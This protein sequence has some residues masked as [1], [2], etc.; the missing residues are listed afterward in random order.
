[1]LYCPYT[2]SPFWKSQCHTR[3]QDATYLPHKWRTNGADSRQAAIGFC[4]VYVSDDALKHFRTAL[5]DAADGNWKELSKN[6]FY[7]SRFA[8]RPSVT[9]KIVGDWTGER[10]F[11]TFLEEHC[12]ALIHQSIFG[13]SPSERLIDACRLY[14]QAFLGEYF[15][16]CLKR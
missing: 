1:M 3:F 11:F 9:E 5:K 13:A 7:Q 14:A 8:G 4:E 15:R 6:P 16:A 10:A 2:N 12:L